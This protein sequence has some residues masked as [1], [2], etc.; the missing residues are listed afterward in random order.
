MPIFRY[1]VFVGGA[2][3]ALL[4][5]ADYVL[6]SQPVARAIVTASN[7]Q[8]L[9]R[10]RSDRHL[11][12]RVVLDTS[13]PTIAAPAVKTA[14]V[15]APQAP[16]QEAASPELAEMSAKA[17]VRETFAQFTP[18]PK[19]NAAAARKTEAKPQV[20]AQAQLPQG[21]TPQI[22]AQPKRKVARAHPAPQQ[23]RSMMLVAQQPH[24]GLFNTTW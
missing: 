17:R 22:Q 11:P 9:I 7:D 15:V 20:Q 1:F 12:E 3:L 21:Q 18:A 19:A 23:G 16:V 10:I 2:L 14:A 6:P 5:A 24:F 8:P 4:F 13:Q